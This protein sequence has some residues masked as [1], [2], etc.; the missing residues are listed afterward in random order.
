VEGNYRGKGRWYPGRISRVNLDG[1]YN[2]D[3]DDGEK[4]LRV[5]AEFVRVADGRGSGGT[6]QRRPALESADLNEG[7]KV[8]AN[9]RGEGRW[10]PGVVARIRLD[11]SYEVHY[12]NGDREAQVPLERLRLSSTRREVAVAYAEGDGIEA[13]YRNRGEWLPGR[14]R[15]PRL[16]GTY[17]VEY[18]TGN[19]EDSVPAGLLRKP[20]ND[21]AAKREGYLQ[22]LSSGKQGS[23]AKYS[24]GLRVACYWYRPSSLGAARYCKK[25]KPAIVLR[26]NSD[27]TYTVELTEDGSIL[28][29]VEEKYLKTWAE[30]TQDLEAEGKSSEGT[31]DEAAGMDKWVAVFKMAH[32]Y[33]KFKKSSHNVPTA[34]SLLT[35]QFRTPLDK[36][37]SILGEEVLREFRKS[38]ERMDRRDDRELGL[39]D[40]L[41]G[42]ADM[43]A[44]V[45][46]SEL[47]TWLRAS[48]SRLSL[49]LP[50]YVIAYA[51]LIYPADQDFKGLL[52]Q[53]ASEA[54]GRTLRL[55]GEDRDMAAFAHKFGKKLLRELEHAFDSLATTTAGEGSPRL[56]ARDIIEAFLSMGKAITVSRLQEWMTDADI[57]PRDRLT[58]ADFAAVYAYF[59]APARESLSTSRTI[60][61]GTAN[62]VRLTLAELAVQVLQEE[63]WRGTQDQ[64]TTFVRRLCA[65]RSDQTIHCTGKLRTAFENLDEQNTGEVSVSR[66]LDLLAEAQLPVSSFVPVAER[67]KDILAQQGRGRFSFPEVFEHFGPRVQEFAE[68]SVSVAEAIS[69]MR[70]HCSTADVR[71][72]VDL[73]GRIL[74][75]I[76]KHPTDHKYWQINAGGQE[77]H[78]KIW[79]YEGGKMLMRA[80]GFGEPAHTHAKDGS[81]K[82]VLGLAH[83]PLDL[84]KMHKLPAELIARLNSYRAELESEVVALEGAPSVAAAL[85][86]MR[87]V[88]SLAE[89]RHGLETALS[90]VRNVLTDPKDLRKYR[91]KKSNPA[92]Q[93]SLGRLQGSALLM[94]AVGFVGTATQTAGAE[95]EDVAAYVLKSVN[96]VGTHKLDKGVDPAFGS[97][98]DLGTGMT[99][100]ICASF[101]PI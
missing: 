28:D 50:D 31:K 4:E 84:A 27:G 41:E 80:V 82:Q 5:A 62:A 52:K 43:G 26:M 11:G 53:D 15:R 67:F 77:F 34:A 45:S 96:P 48:G 14:I 44:R 12:D 66:L 57:T 74:D 78:A 90:I 16:D 98:A 92:F 83:L 29:D 85:R 68:S 79:Q 19:I 46:A 24:R 70:L 95:G 36:L 22:K 49:T 10:L 72:A 51:N 63:K 40:A 23:H 88:H 8:E 1:S 86:E 54:L 75:N 13:N 56:L 30:G 99:V 81:V 87:Q 9:Y 33:V 58:L 64:M 35:S 97:T 61:D 71:L 18:D 42:Y 69:M 17:D 100:H 59:F 60:L 3:Y 2:V 20:R 37:E 94:N 6:D 55:T 7:T 39:E 25:P 89:V 38:F 21:A 32:S 91:V 93:R 65:G 76:I 73:C 47:R 101:I